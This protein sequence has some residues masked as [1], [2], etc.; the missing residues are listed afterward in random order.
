MTFITIVI[1][2]TIMI[3]YCT[4]VIVVKFD[5]RPALLGCSFIVTKQVVSICQSKGDKDNTV[6]AFSSTTCFVPKAMPMHNIF[7]KYFIRNLK[8]VE[9]V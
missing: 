7:C 4:I 9:R 2:F 3:C 6:L 5:Y 1:V 8:G